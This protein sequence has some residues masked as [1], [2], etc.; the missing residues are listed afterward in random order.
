MFPANTS[1]MRRFG[2]KTNPWMNSIHVLLLCNPDHAHSIQITFLRSI[3]PNANQTIFLSKQCCRIA[4][5]VRIGS[6][7]NHFQT[8]ILRTAYQAN[9]RATTCV[10]QHSLYL[11]SVQIFLCGIYVFFVAHRQLVFTGQYS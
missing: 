2:Q 8:S 10:N 11:A 9:C 5:H 6:Y 1:V 3:P 4:F 7:Q